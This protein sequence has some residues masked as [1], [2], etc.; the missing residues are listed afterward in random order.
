LL[1]AGARL[2]GLP[3]DAHGLDPDAFAR[4]CRRRRVRLLY[5]TPLHHYPT[6]VTLAAPRRAA[7][8]AVAA[9][10]GVTILEDDYDH[11]YHYGSLPLPPLAADDPAGLVVYVSTLSKLFF[12]S[13]RLGFA[14]VPERLR[15]DFLRVRALT[16]TQNDALMQDAF[17][18]W[19]RD[20][21]FLRHL[22]RTRR[23]Y[24]KRRDAML[25]TLAAAQARGAALDFAPP[26]GGMAVWLGTPWD[27]ERLAAAAEREGLFVQPEAPNRLDGGPGR[28]LRLGFAGHTPE[29]AAAGLARL[30]ALGA[31]LPPF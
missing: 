17:A 16:S 29:E 28:H 6:T 1:A 30:L 2:V 3:L 13:A 26:E 7:V 27:T 20:G 5:L 25:A 12:P 22:R 4:L 31:R 21:G 18:R 11:E 15:A 19:M 10:H 9:R 14:V 8:Y 24:A 23:T